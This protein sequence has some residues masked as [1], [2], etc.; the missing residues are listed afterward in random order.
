MAEKSNLKRAI[1]MKVKLTFLE[2]V[3]GTASADPEIHREFIASKA[4]DAP[5]RNEKIEEEIESVGLDDVVEKQM[6]VFPRDKDGNPILWDYQIRGFF[7]SAA[8]AMSYVGGDK[9]LTAYKKKIDLLVF[10]NERQIPFA[11]PD[12]GKVMDCQ[13]PLR[14][15]TAQGERVALA[16]SETVPSG[17]TVEFTIHLEDSSLKDYVELWLDYGRRNGIGQWRNSGK[18]TFT[19]EKV[20]DWN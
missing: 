20:D 19:W 12:G 18:G 14:A 13:R 6:T 11:M 17:S 1:E 16:N 8:Q 10:I 15:Q 3:L 5:T 4:P 7:K 2:E 9:K